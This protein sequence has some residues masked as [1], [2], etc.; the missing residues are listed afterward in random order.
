MYKISDYT[1]G[2]LCFH[3]VSLLIQLV[4]LSV[5]KRGNA[6]YSSQISID[7]WTAYP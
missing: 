5:I 2:I 4:L 1:V 6:Y 7:G 3:K